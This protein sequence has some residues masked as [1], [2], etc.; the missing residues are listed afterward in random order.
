MASPSFRPP[1]TDS[2]WFWAY[3]F[4]TAALLALAVIGPKFGPRQAQLER[5]FQ[6]RQR[7][8][9]HQA[10]DEP[11]VAMSDAGETVIGLRP[12]FFALAG[13]TMVAWF[14]FWRTRVARQASGERGDLGSEGCEP[15]E[16]PKGASH[17]A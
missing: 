8:V 3:L 17:R 12:L 16:I 13:I 6:G 15:S 2:P 5:E 1:I 10:G 4:G 14:I 11:T 9:Q 7:A